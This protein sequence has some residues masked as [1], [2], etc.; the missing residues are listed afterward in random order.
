MEEI[1]HVDAEF[2]QNYFYGYVFELTG[3]LLVYLAVGFAVAILLAIFWAGK[4]YQSMQGL[5]SSVVLQYKGGERV[6]NE[7]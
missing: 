3:I 2:S 7:F 6:R 5:I 4:Q 1:L